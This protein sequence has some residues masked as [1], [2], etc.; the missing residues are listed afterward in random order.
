MCIQKI[1]GELERANRE[2]SLVAQE[3]DKGGGSSSKGYLSR[4]ERSPGP[5]EGC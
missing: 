3:S 1:K 5:F 4:I 2:W